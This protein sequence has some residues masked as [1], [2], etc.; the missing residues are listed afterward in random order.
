MIPRQFDAHGLAVRMKQ[1]RELLGYS[2]FEVADNAEISYC[3][4]NNLEMERVISP[5]IETLIRVAY[6]LGTTPE[7]LI[8]GRDI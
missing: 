4:V 6:A 8:F 1:R 5:G 7:W 2:L 3:H